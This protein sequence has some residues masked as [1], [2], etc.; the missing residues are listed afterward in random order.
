MAELKTTVA[1]MQ[2]DVVELKRDVRRLDDSVFQLMLLQFATIA[3]VLTTIVVN[4]L[5]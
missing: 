1:H 3:T 2:G 4:V 5:T